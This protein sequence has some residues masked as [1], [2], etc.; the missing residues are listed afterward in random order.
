MII[1]ANLDWL[2][3]SVVSLPAVYS[4]IHE[5]LSERYNLEMQS[6]LIR[7]CHVAYNEY[8]NL[9]THINLEYILIE[10]KP[11]FFWRYLPDII[12]DENYYIEYIQGMFAALGYYIHQSQIK[13]NRVDIAIDYKGEFKSFDDTFKSIERKKIQSLETIRNVGKNLTGRSSYLNGSG[14]VINRYEKS[15]EIAQTEKSYYPDIYRSDN[16]IRLEIRVKKEYI[17]NYDKNRH[18][19]FYLFTKLFEQIDDV[20]MNEQNIFQNIDKIKSIKNSIKG[21]YM[22]LREKLISDILNDLELLNALENT[23]SNSEND[24]EI[25]INEIID[26][27]S[28]KK[29]KERERHYK[30]YLKSSSL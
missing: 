16:I 15:K 3:F 30:H 8:L 28:P 10:L 25:L 9:H 22:I 7:N 11:L 19:F 23:Y 27:Y 21:E 17:K 14:W 1:R 13:F 5:D 18:K 20:E 6:Y 29:L 24:V 12:S 4:N 2:T 26:R